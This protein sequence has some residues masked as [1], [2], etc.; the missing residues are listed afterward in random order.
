MAVIEKRETKDGLL[1]YRVKVRIKGHPVQTETFNRLTD[2]KL[3]AQKTE[4]AIRDGFYFPRTESRK[5]T[6]AELIERYTTEV[7]PHHK[8]KWI[9]D[10][11]PRLE[12]WKAEIG[13][14]LVADITPTIIVQC[15]EKLVRETIRGGK[16]RSPTSANR[17]LGALSH[18]FT[19]A[20]NEWDCL[21]DNP[22]RKVKK[23][24]EP[25]GRSRYLTTDE[26]E[27]LLVA[28]EQS[29]CCCLYLI[30][31]LA[32][33][34]G[35][36]RGEILKLHW[37]DLHLKEGFLVLQETKN[38]ESRR[39]ALHGPALDLLKNHRRVRRIDTDLVFPSPSSDKPLDIRSAWE[40]ARK[41][42][43]LEDFRFHD[44]R[45]CAASYLA[46]NGATLRDIAEVLGHKTL[47]MVK[48]YSH[49]SEAHTSQVVAKMNE[50]LFSQLSR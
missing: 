14:S 30:V 19:I 23:F 35:M 27:S 37:R 33:S 8:P 44:L 17:Y 32:V 26:L 29:R 46:M 25:R 5:H 20:V 6:L 13:S 16:K 24:R 28:C 38:S 3:W 49:L 31:I 22:S 1:K 2:A 45:H 43:G 15:R 41:R 21:D 9:S 18:V 11:K 4:V 39:V 7:L 47:R 10:L 34:T 36:R 40:I 48:R 42:A 12:W 50:S